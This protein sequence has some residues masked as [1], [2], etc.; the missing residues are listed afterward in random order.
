MDSHL[1]RRL[2]LARQILGDSFAQPVSIARLAARSHLSQYHFIRQFEALFGVTPHQFRI[3]RR[4]D[5][6]CQMLARG[7]HS[8]TEVC[9]EVGMS[10]LGSFSQ[11]FHRRHGCSPS[12][13]R[14]RA[15]GLVSVPGLLPV[16]LFPGCFSLMGSLPPDAFRNFGEVSRATSG[17]E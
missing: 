3:E 16:A 8:V 17:L 15:R 14:R 12:V 7:N 11:S 6:A 1:F 5:R 10:S 4:L 2:C 13:Y 9:F